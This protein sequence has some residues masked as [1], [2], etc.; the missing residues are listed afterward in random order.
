MTLSILIIHYK[1]LKLTTDCIRSIEAHT[2]GI[3][4]EVIVIDNDSQDGA[5]KLILADFPYVRWLDMGYNAGFA[6]A[7]N[8]GIRV[9]KGNNVVLL[10]SDTL[11]IDDIFTKMVQHLDN[12]PD[13]VACGGIQLYENQIKRPFY[14]SIAVFLRTF[15]VLPPSYFFDNVLEKLLPE[16]QFSDPQQVEWIPAALLMVRK[17]TIEKAGML[18]EDFFMYGED[19]EWNCRLGRAGRL[20]VYDDCRY[21]HYEW[22]SDSGRRKQ[23]TT[24]INRFYP[25]I[26]L[27]NLVWIRK[28]YGLIP[29]LL[30]MFNYYVMLVFYFAWKMIVNIKNGK[31]PLTELYHQRD[32]ARKLRIFANYFWKIVLNKTYFYKLHK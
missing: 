24:P 16:K 11:L 13:V 19:A 28:E 8:A 26:H 1:T 25:Q 15:V 9:A 12:E 30:L 5:K 31:N 4:Y 3:D 14:K 18:D 23:E 10:N 22:G 21:I 7:N 2:K 32:Y 20:K 29:Y 17:S 6:R 27:S